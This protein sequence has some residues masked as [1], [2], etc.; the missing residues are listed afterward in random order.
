MQ[1]LNPTDFGYKQHRMQE[2]AA[3]TP[4]GA[5]NE[6]LVNPDLWVNV[7]PRVKPG[8]TILCVAKD[9]SYTA[10]LHVTYSAGQRIRVKLIYRAEL[11]DVTGNMEEDPNSPYF[12]KQRGM[13][14]W[15]IIERSTAEV[16]IKN[17]ATR[18]EAE[19]ALED[20]LRA[21]AA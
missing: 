18:R 9:Y 13:E 19:R 1:P 8:D 5:T 16:K 15:C 12:I 20:Y 2:F 4:P 6:D 3:G 17:I 21:L 11:D 7:A 14:K 10:L